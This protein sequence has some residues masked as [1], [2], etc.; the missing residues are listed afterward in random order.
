MSEGGKLR[1]STSLDPSRQSQGG[2][3][4]LLVQVAD[5]GSGI[6][7]NIRETLF[8][9]FVKSKEKGV[10]LGLSISSKI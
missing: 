4:F 6:P 10:G 8:D 2:R 9:P 5:T 7:E 1:I 3:R